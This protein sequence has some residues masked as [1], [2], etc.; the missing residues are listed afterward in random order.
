M[1]DKQRSSL[2]LVSHRDGTLQHHTSCKAYIRKQRTALEA[3]C[4][5]EQHVFAF[6]PTGFGKHLAKHGSDVH[7]AP[8][9]VVFAS[10]KNYLT[11]LAEKNLIGLLESPFK[12]F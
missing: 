2:F 4:F 12:F 11:K 5:G 6:L 1:M 10:C 8:P 7:L 3:F 9:C